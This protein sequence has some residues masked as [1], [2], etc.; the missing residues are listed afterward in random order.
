VVF[1]Q[2][3]AFSAFFW[4]FWKS[5]VSLEEH[6]GFQFPWSLTQIIPLTTG[7]SYHDH[8]HSN[9][10][11]NYSGSCYFWDVVLGTAE[12][13]FKVYLKDKKV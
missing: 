2:L 3:H 4:V 8:H 11:G 6:S 5:T 7:S 12:D 9:N 13:Y 1:G 10:V